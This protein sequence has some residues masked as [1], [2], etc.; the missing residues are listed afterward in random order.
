MADTDPTA[1]AAE[2]LVSVR[3]SADLRDRL[4]AAAESNHRTMSG[5]VRFLIERSL[6]EDDGK[7]PA[8]A[9]AVHRQAA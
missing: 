6:H 8:S 7:S 9:D 1:D 2:T 5:Q 3:L 4:R